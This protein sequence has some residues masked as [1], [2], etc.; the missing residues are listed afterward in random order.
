M[1]QNYI[2]ISP[3]YKD[4]RHFISN[5]PQMF[6]EKKGDLI[7]IGRNEIRTFMYQGKTLVVK[8]FKTYNL[9]KQIIYTF[10]RR[11][12]A[13]RAF[14]NAHELRNRGFY[15]PHEIG[16]IIVHG[17]IGM[18]K[19]TY[20]ICEFDQGKAI[21]EILNNPNFDKQMTIEFAKYVASLHKAGIIHHD[22]NSTNILYHETNGNKT[23]SLI[24]INRMEFVTP[25]KLK[26]KKCMKNLTLFCESGE[27]FTLFLHEYI[28]CRGWNS[29]YYNKAMNIKARHDISYEKRKKLKRKISSLFH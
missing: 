3:E 11:D 18:A 26:N 6:A 22:L 2:S 29:E 27:M 5:I 21:S 4:I 1:R 16:Y 24:D 15:T 9:L 17:T 7:Y 13:E 12:K 19:Q 23:F 10:F 14:Y 25:G 8:K 28:H 20:Y